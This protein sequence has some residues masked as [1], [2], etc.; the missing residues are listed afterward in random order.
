MDLSGRAAL[1]T[2]APGGLGAA[3]CHISP[4]RPPS[5]SRHPL[6]GGYADEST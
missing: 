3:G 4:G 1:V 5:Q 2:G 6:Q